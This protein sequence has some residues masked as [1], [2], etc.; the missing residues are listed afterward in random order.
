MAEPRVQPSAR[1]VEWSSI[2]ERFAGNG[3]VSKGGALLVG[4]GFSTNIWSEFGYGTLLD[5]S[6]LAGTALS[7]F[8]RR[9]NFET[10]LAEL[11]IT[12]Q[13]LD[14][15]ACDQRA[16]KVRLAEL[17]AEVRDGL[18]QA[19]GD[20]HPEAR[21]L[22]A[23]QQRRGSFGWVGAGGVQVLDEVTGYMPRYSQVFVTNY[24]LLSYWTTVKAEI[25]DLFPGSESFDLTRAEG[26]LRSNAQP[27][28]F[29]LHGALHLWRS[30]LTNAEGKHTSTLDVALLDVIRSSLDTPERVPLFIS[31][32]SSAE[33][34]ARISASPY[35]SFCSRQ[36]ANS[37]AP[38]TVLG[39]ALN[40][41]DRHICEA[42]ERHPERGVA[43]GVWVGDILKNKQQELVTRATQIQGRLSRCR[44]VVF[45][46]SADHPL[47]N[48]KLHC[49]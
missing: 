46:D 15:V 18:L 1:V 38:L 2:E 21:E 37:S 29:F 49:K 45:F 42:I 7:L 4:N 40:D 27:K 34:V 13:V 5:R 24:D 31:E 23:G 19:V 32:G 36:L 30:L 44:D 25:A 39:Q 41:V 10:V 33:K 17:S 48:L 8:G 22:V 35:L 20:V 16:L 3:E 47:T 11:S 26:W 6:G 43:V 12:R 14:V 9:S 28:V